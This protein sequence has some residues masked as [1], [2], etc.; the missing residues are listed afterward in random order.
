MTVPQTTFP[1]CKKCAKPMTWVAE[2]FVES[3]PVEVFHCESCDR[4]AAAQL[5]V[6]DPKITPL[7]A[8]TR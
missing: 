7:H 5:L 4:Y 3:D 2:H 8:G 6:N 1:I